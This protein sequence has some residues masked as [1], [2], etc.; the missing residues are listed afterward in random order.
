[1]RQKSVLIALLILVIL[2]IAGSL[3]FARLEHKQESAV[4]TSSNQNLSPA[5]QTSVEPSPT[6]SEAAT[7]AH[8][9]S[10]DLTADATGLSKA[11]VV[12]TTPRGVFKFKFY[13]NDAPQTVNRI[14]EL[15]GQGF[16][17]NL[18]F[19]RVSPGFLIQGGDP[20]GDGTGGSGKMIP[21]E[22]NSRKHVEGTLAMAHKPSNPNSADS[23]F[24][25][26]L[27]TLPNLDGKSTVFGQ[28]IQGIDVIK[29][30]E[31]FDKM[32]SVVIE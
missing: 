21:A 24:Y 5:P 28:V 14:V 9:T 16:Y 11:T 23:Q 22:F 26:A 1:M 31:K 32:T 19:H 20:H 10:P 12:V 13:T 7:P 25:I 15:I 2:G 30:I 27:G 17:N 29:K 18:S 8:P 4:G 6:L 3:Y